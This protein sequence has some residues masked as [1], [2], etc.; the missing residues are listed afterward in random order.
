[1]EKMMLVVK[2][3]KQ[4][5]KAIMTNVDEVLIVGQQA[6]DILQKIGH[7][8]TVKERGAKNFIFSSHYKNF[9]VLELKYNT[10]VEG[11][12]LRKSGLSS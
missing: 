12:L 8:D 10:V 2:T 5:E 4:L 9:E 7:H 11:H 1:V 3:L 6:P